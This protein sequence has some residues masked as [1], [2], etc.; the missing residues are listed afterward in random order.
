VLPESWQIPSTSSVRMA[1]FAKFLDEGE[2]AS[3]ILADPIDLFGSNGCI[4]EVPR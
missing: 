3:R 1:A 4:R 2:G